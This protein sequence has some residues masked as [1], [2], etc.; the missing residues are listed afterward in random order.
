[1]ASWYKDL[2]TN[3]STNITKLQRTYFGGETDG[4][5]EDDTHVC[6]VLR[7]Y[8]TEKGQPFPGWLPPDPKAPPP[9]QPVYANQVGSRYGGFSSNNTQQAGAGGASLSS[10]WDNNSNNQSAQPASLRQGRANPF[11]NRTGSAPPVR[12]GREEVQSRPLPSQRAGSYQQQA[13]GYGR[14][15]APPPPPVSSTGGASAQEKLKQR[16]WGGARTTSPGSSGG[17]FQAPAPQQQPP[18]SGSRWGGNSGGGGNYEDRFAPPGAYDGRDDRPVMSANAP[19][20]GGDMD[21]YSGGNDY[22]SSGGGGGGGRRPAGGLPSGPRRGGL[23]NGP[24]M[25]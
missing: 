1:M 25:R 6:R 15:D 14:N 17:P 18:Q 4:D 11:A 3:A 9:V 2:L 8:Y 13:G 21:Y 22:S 12:G 10:L 5:T 19:W 20:A 24:R 7:A 16:L 23:P